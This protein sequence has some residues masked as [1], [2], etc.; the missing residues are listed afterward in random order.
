M[1]RNI[2]NVKMNKLYEFV[3]LKSIHNQTETNKSK[4]LSIK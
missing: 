1:Y 2:L 3:E 4:I